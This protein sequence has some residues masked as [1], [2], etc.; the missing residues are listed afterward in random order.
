MTGHH[1]A[2]HYCNLDFAIFKPTGWLIVVL[3]MSVTRMRNSVMSML[4]RRR[5]HDT[6]QGNREGQN[7]GDDSPEHALYLAP[8]PTG[9][10]SA[11]N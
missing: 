9:T 6:R 5:H 4:L 8:P 7:D 11:F 3:M 2:A 1:G 10:S